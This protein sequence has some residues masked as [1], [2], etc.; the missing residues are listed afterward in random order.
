MKSI[1]F[2]EQNVVFAEK[3]DEYENLPARVD[4]NGIVTCCM[5]LEED[6]LERVLDTGEL[7]ISRICFKDPP[8]PIKV[9]FKK[10]VFPVSIKGFTCEPTQWAKPKDATGTVKFCIHLSESEIDQLGK[11]KLFWLCT[12]TYKSAFQPIGP[13]TD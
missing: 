6:E 1:E 13:R 7:W 10:P 2:K 5:Q 12:A 4:G 8:Q 3:Q 11:T 9:A